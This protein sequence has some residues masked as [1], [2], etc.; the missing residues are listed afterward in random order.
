MPYLSIVTVTLNNLSGLKD[1]L[2]SIPIG[3]PSIEWILID[4]SS[5]DGTV[6]FVQHLEKKPEVFISE[7]DKGI[8]HAM[9]KGLKYVSGEIVIFLNSGDFFID[10]TVPSR[11]IDSYAKNS[12]VWA[13][14]G[15]VTVDKNKN[16]LWVWPKLKPKSLKL[17]LAVNSYCHQATAYETTSLKTF[18]GFFEDSLY[19]DWST[20]LQFLKIQPPYIDNEF[21]TCF[22]V[23]GVSS[24]MNIDF[25]FNEVLKLR[26]RVDALILKNKVID[27]VL[28]RLVYQYLLSKRGRK[29]RT[30]LVQEND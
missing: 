5:S 8:F 16:Q 9:N 17:R 10:S 21:W 14:G 13:V 24:Q 12:W 7:P 4:G 1:T 26:R 2:A 19:S 15:A 6:E 23:G 3:H 11:I 27:Y 18:G 30:D 29:I 28:Q 22:L 25:W 20:S